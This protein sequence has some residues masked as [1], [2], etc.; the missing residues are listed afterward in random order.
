MTEPIPDPM[1]D[2]MTE[3]WIFL[4]L[5]GTLLDVSRRYQHLHRD[6]VLRHGGRPLS[7][8]DYWALKR[9][10]TPEAEILAR[11]GVPSEAGAEIAA[12]RERHLEERRYLRLDRP[13]PWTAAVLAG[14][15]PY[16]RLALI[17]LR[18][19][20]D[21]LLWQLDTLGLRAPFARVVSGR[22]DG[23]PQAKA[24]LVRA[25]GI[26]PA[27]GSLLVGDTEVDI[28]SGK[29]LGVRTAAVTCGLRDAAHL[30]AWA[31][32]LLLDDLRGLPAALATGLR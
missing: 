16:G 27:P 18:S 15:A 25:A 21:R 9:S 13:W 3:R 2:P 19:H 12:A 31:P 24:G 11:A 14:L 6:L 7:R 28:A 29:A 10:R 8:E 32:D 30:A 17:T 1:T 4:D 20:S 5:D 26:D 23:T 22:G